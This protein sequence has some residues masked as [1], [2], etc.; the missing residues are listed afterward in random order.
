MVVPWN[1]TLSSVKH[2]TFNPLP[3]CPLTSPLHPH[4]LFAPG[5]HIRMLSPFQCRNLLRNVDSGEFQIL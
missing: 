5:L 2:W 4:A 3:V 1:D